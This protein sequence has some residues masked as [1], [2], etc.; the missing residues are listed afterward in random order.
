MAVPLVAASTTQ[1]PAR[2]RHAASGL[3]HARGHL[4]LVGDDEHGEVGQQ[5]CPEAPLALQ[6]MAE[7]SWSPDD[8]WITMETWPTGSNHDIAIMTNA[9]SNYILLAAHPAADFDPAWRP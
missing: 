9:C 2:R 3:V 4:V 7:G 6:P 8:Q 5:V 1:V